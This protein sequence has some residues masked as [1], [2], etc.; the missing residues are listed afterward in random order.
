MGAMGYEF[1]TENQP[2][3]PVPH[4]FLYSKNNL[5]MNIQKR[6]DVSIYCLSTATNIPEWFGE[7][8]RRNL[9]KK[10]ESVRRRIELIQDFQM[11]A[12][13]NKIVQS[14]DGRY[15]IAA[16]TY[17]PRIRCYDTSELSMKFERY[18]NGTV[19][20]MVM[21]GE[22]YGKIAILMDD[23]SV[24]FHAPYGAHE[25]IRIPAFGRALAYESTTCE[26]LIAAKGSQVFRFS[27]E[28][29]RFYEPWSFETDDTSGSCITVNPAY[30]VAAIGCEDGIVRFWDNRSPDSL[31]PFLR[32]DVKA[33]VKGY[34]FADKVITPNPY[35]ITS[36][37]YDPSGMYL[38]VG[39]SGGVVA[40]YDVRSSKPLHIKEHKHGVSIHTI[41]FHP[42]SGLLFSSDEKLIKV[43]RYKSKG[44]T[45]KLTNLGMTENTVSSDNSIGALRVN[46][47]SKDRLAHFIIAG[48]E[49]DPFGY[50][51]GDVLCA[52][53]QPKM[54]S[55]FIPA[56][57][58][59]PKW[60]SFLDSITE[61]LEERDLNRDASN[62]SDLV[63]DG[64]ESVFENYK[65]VSRDDLEKLGVAHLIG[66]PL[67][68]GYMHGFFMDINLY[69]KVRSV[70]NPFEYEEYQKKKLKERIEAK[71]SSRIAPRANDRKKTASVNPELADRLQARSGDTKAGK[72][73]KNL[74]TDD[75][76]GTLFTN[77]D[78]EI[79]EEDEDFKLRN[80][81]GVAAT[82][83]RKDNM[84]SDEESEAEELQPSQEVIDDDRSENSEGSYSDSEDD[85][86]AGGKVRGEAY[87]D[88]KKQTK[89]QRKGTTPKLQ[90]FEGQSDLFDK[91]RKSKLQKM[92]QPISDRLAEQSEKP[93]V[94]I[95]GGNKEASF[96][97][98]DKRKKQ[99][100][101][102][103]ERG[104]RHR[105]SMNDLKRKR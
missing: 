88:M 48:D 52:T 6:N 18:M 104:K 90:E 36:I 69:N 82:N 57:G 23:R 49:S 27:L 22:D 21:L 62:N 66:T 37:S 81:S 94:R 92:H 19:V 35:E 77:P 89:K 55:Y 12:S 33:A 65:F 51:S 41:R 86:L 5:T 91:S 97:P 34:G 60:C 68:R 50:K 46:I 73:A 26:L 47:E 31:K 30:P 64:N 24:A 32:L 80:P 76:F 67:L 63:R 38:A 72:V 70:A 17:P 54:E 71:R 78:F 83:R 39:T 25:T 87:G 11:P 75:R 9:A 15:I 74:L 13:S 56:V 40:L 99:N 10:D 2:K 45:T 53:H 16:G 100:N 20:D 79:D 105:R 61:E 8:A 28:E 84:D 85:G 96:I 101:G 14:A 1:F 44:D 42:G 7:Q 29:G 59:A 98:K 102:G 4:Y 93:V 58:L 103:E 43:W 3:L 95:S